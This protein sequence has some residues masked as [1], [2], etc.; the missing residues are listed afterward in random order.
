MGLTVPWPDERTE[1]LKELYLEGTLTMTQ[2]AWRLNN[3][4]G[5]LLT[6]NAVCGKIH[7]LC[8]AGKLASRGGKPPVAYR[9]PP[10]ARKPPGVKIIAPPITDGEFIYNLAPRGCRYA[11]GE[12]DGKH[13]FCNH[14]QQDGSSYCP[15]HTEVCQPSRRVAA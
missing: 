5:T 13:T 14:Q 11:I 12:R 8:C 4:F 1:R 9:R 10:V 6:K 3:E 15:Y 2:I 7:N